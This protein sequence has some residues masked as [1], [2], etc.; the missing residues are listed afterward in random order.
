MYILCSVGNMSKVSKG[1]C[2]MMATEV[3]VTL[4]SV[5]V[6]VEIRL[7]PKVICIHTVSYTHLTLP[8][9]YSV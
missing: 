9:I 7:L 3:T 6:N 4:H 1:Q 2:S 8:T 5:A